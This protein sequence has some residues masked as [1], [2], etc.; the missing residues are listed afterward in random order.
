MSDTFRA[1]IIDDEELGRR[2]VKKY[3]AAFPQFHLAGEASNG[4]QGMKLI[5]EHDPDVIFLDIQM[6]KLTGF[7]LLELIEKP[8]SVIFT[9]AYDQYAVQAFE[10]SA[11]DYLLKPFSADRFNQ[12]I[13]KF[14]MQNRQSQQ[15]QVEKL[16]AYVETEK[17]TIDRLPVKDGSKIHILPLPEIISIEAQDDYILIKTETGKFLKKQTMKS[18]ESLLPSASFVRIHRST[19]V[20][21][22]FIK[23][24]ELYEKD[25]YRVKLSTGQL[26][27]VS[28][29]GYQ[30][31]TS[32]LS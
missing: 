32:I 30:N 15:E 11:I 1:I 4:F 22:S 5:H 21:V 17:R 3:L 6:P 18:I 8:V 2:I 23:E 25:A 19:I 26:L 16:K 13:E 20:N 10:A 24:I 12:A 7:E 14:L 27:E 9:T 31:L 29:T 28:K